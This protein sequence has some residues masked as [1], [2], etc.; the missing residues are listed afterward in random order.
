M[1]IQFFSPSKST[2]A[3]LLGTTGKLRPDSR[4]RKAIWEDYSGAYWKPKSKEFLGVG[5]WRQLLEVLKLKGKLIRILTF[6][7]LQFY[8]LN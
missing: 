6:K 8:I 3:F 7:I 5:L 4:R 1:R 2:A